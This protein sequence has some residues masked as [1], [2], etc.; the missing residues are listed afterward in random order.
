MTIRPDLVGYLVDGEKW[1]GARDGLSP[2]T[3][4]TTFRGRGHGGVQ[5]RFGVDH[6]AFTNIGTK[7]STYT[8]S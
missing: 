6:T 4:N 1:V 5:H 2:S 3:R 8:G 7:L